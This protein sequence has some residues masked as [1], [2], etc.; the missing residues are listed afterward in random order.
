[1]PPRPHLAPV[2]L[3]A[4]MNAH[5]RALQYG[6]GASLA[7]RVYEMPG[8]KTWPIP[9]QVAFI[10][11]FIR[12]CSKDPHL[13]E[14]A[15]RICRDAGVQPRNTMG[16]WAAL[17]R[18]VQ[19]RIYYVNE[20]DERLQS[21]QYTV[22]FGYGD[23]DDKIILLCALGDAL[24][25]PWKLVISGNRGGVKMRWVEGTPLPN[26]VVWSH[27]YGLGGAPP[28]RPDL[29]RFMEPTLNVPLGWDVISDSRRR[30]GRSVLPEL[31][32]AAEPARASPPAVAPPSPVVVAATAAG[33]RTWKPVQFVVKLP[34]AQIAAA[35]I[36]PIAAAFIIGRATRPAAAPSRGT[37]ACKP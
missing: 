29:W 14:L 10:R 30:A 8:W 3:D 5:L 23:C 24:R 4:T 11:A 12:S 35:T 36:P 9:R 32:A 19:C 33:F 21:A 15:V 17:L 31:G 7:G 28:F 25:L 2:E 16:Q 18:W 22:T 26:G 37:C 1:M 20:R 13:V 6:K 34:W 27:I